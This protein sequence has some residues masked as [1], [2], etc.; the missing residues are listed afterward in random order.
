MRTIGPSLAFVALFLAF[1]VLSPS[2]LT[3]ENALNILRQSCNL[4]VVALAGTFVIVSGSIDI[5]VGSVMS[6]TGMTG[7]LLISRYGDWSLPLALLFGVACGAANGFLFAYARLPSFLVT[8][9]TLFVIQGVT[10]LAS[11]GAALAVQPDSVFG[12]IFGGQIGL[13]PAA[14]FWALGLAAL[15]AF[16]ARRTKFGRYMYAIGAGE[17]VARLSGVPVRRFK[18]YAF[19]V[20]GT[21]AGL[22]GVLLL[23][24]L[25]GGDPNMGTPFLLP[26][27]A[28]VV[29]GGTPL[30]GGLGGPVRTLLASSS[31]PRSPM[32]WI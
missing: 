9:G 30:T 7:A 10:N 23:F 15:A 17:N 20:S 18:F 2:F 28:A 25:Q 32:G 29:V 22:A 24:R 6:L 11:G 8:L 1:S 13:F 19:L 14:A 16:V 4:L 27:I 5:S 3:V 12:R 21:L 26:A 31:F